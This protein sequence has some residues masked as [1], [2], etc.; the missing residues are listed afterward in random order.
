MFRTSARLFALTG[1]LLFIGI[2]EASADL[3]GVLPEL[4]DL[5]RWSVFSLGVDTRRDVFSGTAFVEGDV[6]VAGIGNITL[7]DSATIDGNL[8]YRSNG[9]LRT[10]PGTSI[11]GAQIHDQDALLDNAAAAALATSRHAAQLTRNYFAPNDIE[12]SGGRN[13]TVSGTPGATVVMKLGN[14][15]L[16][17]NSSFTLE[18]TA[19]TTF[20]INVTKQFALSGNAQIV[21]S[22]GVLWN[23]VLFNIHTKDSAVSLSGNAKLSGMLIANKRTVQLSGNANV[24]GEVIANRVM[25]SNSG[26]RGNASVGHPPLVSP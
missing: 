5:Q 16:S 22:G 18:G 25:F 15:T 20:I 12:L 8:Y 1:T 26:F 19:S 10:D 23:N 3:G 14:F 2:T 17:G 7:K 24:D 13:F 6:G 11:T 9:T 21:L 4:G